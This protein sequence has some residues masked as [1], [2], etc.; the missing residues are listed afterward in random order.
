VEANAVFA[1]LPPEVT[2]SLQERFPFYVW[3]EH[4]G[5]VRWMCSWD[6]TAEDV[7]RFAAAVRDALA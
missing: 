5:E 7:Q 6:T 2:A 3:D 4:T 1:I